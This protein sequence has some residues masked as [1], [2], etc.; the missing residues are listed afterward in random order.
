MFNQEIGTK[1]HK[2]TLFSGAASQKLLAYKTFAYELHIMF[3][4]NNGMIVFVFICRT[5]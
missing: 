5:D 1:W 3:S 2:V 4:S